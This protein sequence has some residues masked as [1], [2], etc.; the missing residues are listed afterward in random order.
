MKVLLATNDDFI[1]R[2]RTR[3][4]ADS[5]PG[6]SVVLSVLDA[7]GFIAG[8]YV[9]IGYEG[10]EGAEL[11]KVTA[12]TP[13]SVTF[14][15]LLLAH[16]ADEPLVI[17]RFN[18]RKFYGALTATGSFVEITGSGSPVIITVSDPQ[19]T[20][21]EYI[22]NEGYIYFKSTYFNSSTSEETPLSESDA[23]L[24]DESVRYCSLY[25]IRQQAGL[26][27]NPFIT[28]GRIETYRHR[29]ESEVDSYLNARYILP[30]LNS[31]GAAEVPFLVE[32]CTTLLAA[33]YMDYQEF[34][35]DGEGVKW[36]G[37]ARSILKKLQ[38]PGGQQLMGS[39]KIEMQT[40][41]LSSGIA[42]YPDQV[43][44]TNGPARQFTMAQRF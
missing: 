18:K 26:T 27:N 36:L 16:K 14:D 11:S 9:A 5:L 3:L 38:T 7:D 24:A 28:D 8:Q 12:V 33:G 25:A 22:G 19:G 41:T 2:Q 10:S 31:S 13:T 43:D 32:N 44:N 23:I 20:Y 40:R 21:C 30:L 4:A 35:K 6:S 15:T 37:E 29:A 1:K 42:S 34:G 17:F 39:D